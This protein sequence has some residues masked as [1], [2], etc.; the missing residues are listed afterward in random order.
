VVLRALPLLLA[1]AICLGGLF[2]AGLLSSHGIVSK[3]GDRV[4]SRATA[5]GWQG[6]FPENGRLQRAQDFNTV[7][8][9]SVETRSSLQKSAAYA[10]EC[11]GDNA[12]AS[13]SCA[14]FAQ[15]N[16]NSSVDFTA[17]CPFANGT[18][19][20]N[21]S[22]IL[23]DSGLVDSGYDLGVNSRVED[24]VR[25]RKTLTCSPLNMEKYTHVVNGTSVG[26]TFGGTT[27][28]GSSF[29]Q[30]TFY[31]SNI[32]SVAYSG[33]YDMRRTASRPFIYSANLQPVWD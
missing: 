26:F 31:T 25:F 9:L 4:L 22:A 16:L 14:T 5:C 21:V 17:P 6:E 20:T 1:S 28:N 33:N 29:P 3:D 32:S 23:I 7:N 13:T 10:R 8:A 30:Y 27:G 2:A 15:R 19:A 12:D 18:C 11:Y 24:R